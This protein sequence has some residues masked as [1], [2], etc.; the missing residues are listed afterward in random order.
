MCHTVLAQKFHSLKYRRELSYMPSNIYSTRGM[1][2][3][4]E[5]TQKCINSEVGVGREE[6][7]PLGRWAQRRWGDW[8]LNRVD[9][10]QSFERLRITPYSPEAYLCLKCYI[11]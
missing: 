2:E 9:R 11:C 3:K 8:V 5:I 1:S 7:G 4:L 10:E 6:P